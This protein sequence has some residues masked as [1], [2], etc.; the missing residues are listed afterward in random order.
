MVLVPVGG[1][2]LMRGLD[3]VLSS[4]PDTPTKPPTL[5]LL[6]PLLSQRI[7]ESVPAA[8]VPESKRNGVAVERV[9]RDRAKRGCVVCSGRCTAGR[10]LIRRCSCGA[11]KK[12]QQPLAARSCLH[13]LV[14]AASRPPSHEQLHVAPG[15]LHGCVDLLDRV[16]IAEALESVQLA[17]E[18]KAGRGRGSTVGG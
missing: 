1:V 2:W 16:W 18:R 17:A 9:E 12:Q 10:R 3:C 15:R 8:F 4:P 13:A 14:P 6:A 7:H 11:A 5:D